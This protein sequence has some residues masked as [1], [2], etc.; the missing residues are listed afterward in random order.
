VMDKKVAAIRQH[1]SQVLLLG[2]FLPS[3]GRQ[4]ECFSPIPISLNTLVNGSSVSSAVPIDQE[5]ALLPG[6][7]SD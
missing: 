6:P 4:N 2:N 1:A 7:S 3:F 5:L